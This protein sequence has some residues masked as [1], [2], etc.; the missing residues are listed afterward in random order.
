MT[1]R[2]DSFGG[3][4]DGIQPFRIAGLP[5]ETESCRRLRYN[6]SG[7]ASIVVKRS[8]LRREPF[9]FVSWGHIVG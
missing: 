2:S 8:S 9:A 4:D 7:V 3:S 1:A 5:A 6:E